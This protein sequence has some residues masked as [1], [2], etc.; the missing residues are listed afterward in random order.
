MTSSKRDTK[1]K[2]LIMLTSAESPMLPQ[3]FSMRVKYS[4]KLPFKA[5]Q[6]HSEHKQTGSS[7]C[8]V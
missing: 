1:F 4:I 7:V 6:V 8:H 5:L 3:L 2:I